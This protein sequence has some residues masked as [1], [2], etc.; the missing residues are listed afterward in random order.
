MW[1]PHQPPGS[2]VLVLLPRNR[3]SSINQAQEQSRPLW[4]VWA[5]FADILLPCFAQQGD[6]S[7][8]S[9]TCCRRQYGAEPSP[10]CAEVSRGHLYL[11]SAS[12]VFLATGHVKNSPLEMGI[13]RISNSRES[14][15]LRGAKT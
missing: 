15:A 9:S 7:G 13:P 4:R 14:F 2:M 3:G 8:R 11:N 6:C 5:G 1:S 10:G 12:G